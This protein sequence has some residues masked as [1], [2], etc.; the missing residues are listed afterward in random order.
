MDNHSQWHEID[1]LVL[2]RRR[3]HLIKLKHYTGLLQ[4]SETN[5]VRTTLGGKKRTQRCC[6]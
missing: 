2:G 4:G 3:L 6:C 5:W 1:A